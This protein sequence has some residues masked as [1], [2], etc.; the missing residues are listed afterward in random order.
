MYP[1]ISFDASFKNLPNKTFEFMA[2]HVE[3]YDSTNWDC[4]G[5]TFGGD[6]SVKESSIWE[7]PKCCSDSKYVDYIVKSWYD[8]C[9]HVFIKPL[10][11]ENLKSKV[12]HEVDTNYP[13]VALTP[14]EENYEWILIWTV[15]KLEIS[16][17]TLVLYWAPTHKKPS[18]SRIIDDFEI[19]GPE[20][21]PYKI[22]NA[23]SELDSS[24]AAWIQDLTK[25]P[26]SDHPALRLE[27][28]FDQSQEKFRRRIRDARLRS[29]LARYRA[30]KL[31]SQFQQRYGF[32]P[33]E[34]DEEAQTEY[35][36]SSDKD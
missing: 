2:N 28:E 31:A 24:N 33:V 18:K 32:Y 14:E 1:R 35:E 36:T 4:E 5:V 11:L 10:N 8:D 16:K 25:L 15:V 21:T 19:Q 6:R 13:I 34:D 27:T 22:I 7:L 12:K 29:K 26:L 23:V 9:K 30:D 20:D 17:T 3:I